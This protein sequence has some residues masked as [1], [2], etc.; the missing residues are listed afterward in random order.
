MILFE[1]FSSK[2]HGEKGRVGWPAGGGQLGL[3]VVS[4]LHSLKKRNFFL[5]IFS[6]CFMISIEL[7]S[8]K[9]QEKRSGE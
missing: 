5:S 3:A 6:S 2:Y 7:F 4:L 1:S 9:Y 8:T